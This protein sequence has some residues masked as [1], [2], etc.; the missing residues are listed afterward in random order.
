MNNDSSIPLSVSFKSIPLLLSQRKLEST[1]FSVFPFLFSK[2]STTILEPTF[3]VKGLVC[4]SDFL[5]IVG[6]SS[7][8]LFRL[9]FSNSSVFISSV[10]QRIPIEGEVTSITHSTTEFITLSNTPSTSYVTHLRYD[11]H[12]NQ[13]SLT[14]FYRSVFSYQNFLVLCGKTLCVQQNGT[15][16]YSC[17][18]PS[19]GWCITGNSKGVMVG[20]QKGEVVWY[21]WK[22][23][24]RVICRMKT[25]IKECDHW[26]DQFATCDLQGNCC[27][28]LVNSY[29][30]M[31]MTQ[32]RTEVHTTLSLTCCEEG[33]IL[34][35]KE[36]RITID[37]NG[38][39]VDQDICHTISVIRYNSPIL[40]GVSDSSIWVRPERGYYIK[41]KAICHEC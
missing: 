5:L 3:S 37:W 2:L 31:A 11:L 13:R 15:T 22:D 40:C 18:L 8:Y 24:V 9:I 25:G 35:C 6:S 32:I 29:E 21:D 34:G 20:C 38:V 1:P 36:G 26:G 30:D 10:P 41:P 12:S 27:L 14:S 28:F 17:R 7:L 39:I 19:E 33:V 23:Q 4:L 16:V